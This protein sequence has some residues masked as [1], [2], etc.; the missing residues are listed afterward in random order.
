MDD[1]APRTRPYRI[2]VLAQR[3]GRLGPM[4]EGA[5]ER[6]GV[7][8]EISRYCGKECDILA[9]F[10][11]RLP[12]RRITP[13]DTCVPIIYS[14]SGRVRR[15][16]AGCPLPCVS[17][18]TSAFDTVTVSSISRGRAMMTV[19]RELAPLCGGIIEPCE[20]IVSYT[21]CDIYKALLCAAAVLMCAGA[22]GGDG[23]ILP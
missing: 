15:A 21:G 3:Y 10:D 16:L 2:A 1:A 13:P 18:G 4:L 9:A 5:L 14:G 6:A 8:A 19:Q 22:P 20:M 11:T 7:N 12:V 17:C 23:I